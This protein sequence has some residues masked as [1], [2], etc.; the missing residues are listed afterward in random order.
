MNEATFVNPTEFRQVDAICDRFE[1]HLRTG[2]CPRIETALDGLADPVRTHALRELLKIEIEYRRAAGERPTSEQYAARFPHDEK[3]LE[4]LLA[5]P[6]RTEDAGPAS[7]SESTISVVIEVIDGHYKGKRFE[8]CDH[9]SFIVGRGDQAHFQLP[10]RDRRFSRLHFLVEV[11]PPIC[12]LVDLASRNGTK[13]NGVPV[14]AA[15]LQ[16]GDLIRAGRTTLQV[17]ITNTRDSRPPIVRTESALSLTASKTESKPPGPPAVG[18]QQPPELPNIP[19]F[20]IMREL[21]RG[22]MGVVYLA[23]RL[24]DDVLYAIKTIRPVRGTSTREIERFLRECQILK[25]IRNPAIVAFHEMGHTGQLLYL[26]MD[27]VPGTDA[28]QLLKA[29][30]RPSVPLAVNLICQTL[31]GLQY[32]HDSGFVHRDL[33]PANLLVSGDLPSPI[34]R[35]ADFGLARQYHASRV[36]GLTLLGD[37]GGTIPYMAPE[38]I[39]DFRNVQ[40]PADIYSAAA[41]LYYLLTGKYVFDFAQ[42]KASARLKMILSE[43]PIPIRTRRAE[44]SP[45]LA[46][47]VHRGL[48]RNPQERFASAAE[49][50]NMLL[51]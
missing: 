34:C 44:I 40:P 7:S 22:G 29:G 38:Q 28:S 20:Q 30:G 13:V 3:L 1:S 50:R 36:S 9:D 45:E 32:A 17:Q 37:V 49:F 11:N 16:D 51:G 27:Y 48:A 8:F 4:V 46:Q 26:V 24:E 10:K 43:T 14:E 5:D 23:R 2:Q 33:K 19:G 31:A 35:L 15:E 25:S 39:T 12:R 6:S 21:G 18:T 42:L 47:I 41:T